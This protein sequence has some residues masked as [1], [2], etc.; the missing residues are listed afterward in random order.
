MNKL[1]KIIFQNKN[2]DIHK[3]AKPHSDSKTGFYNDTPLYNIKCLI[4][5]HYK[6]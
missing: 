3:S 2:I 5:V 1:N 4:Y 6:L